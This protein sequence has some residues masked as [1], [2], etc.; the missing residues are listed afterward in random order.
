MKRLVLCGGLTLALV[1]A[2]GEVFAVSGTV[3]GMVVDGDGNPV[4]DASV[5][6]QAT[7]GSTLSFKGKT[8]KDGTFL[9]L[10]TG[11]SGPW[12][13]TVS[14]EGYR[15]W[16]MKEPVLIPL[17]GE[18]VVLPAVTLW[19]PD[20]PR[21]PA[22]LNTEE[23]KQLEAERKQFE[24]LSGEY[25]AVVTLLEASDA[26]Q[27][28]GDGALASQKL[29]EAEAGIRAL[30]AKNAAVARLPLTLG[31]VYEKRRQWQSAAEAYL[32]AAELKSDMADA[33]RGAAAMYLSAGQPKKAA[34]VCASGLAVNA[35]DSR[36]QFLLAWARFNEGNYA[37][38]TRQFDKAQQM[39]AADPEPNYYLGVI[40]VAQNRVADSLRLL[41]K[42][43]SMN[44]T[45]TR[46]LKSAQDMLL[47][48]R[49][50]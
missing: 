27:G 3:R 36:L 19:K 16:E 30:I 44:P 25:D 26:A 13:V 45:N 11:T 23:A 42:Y 17:G 39:D 15:T 2:S 10:T 7:R 4:A 49:K 14:K 1:M 12:K 22:V 32:K 9:Q 8:K 5:Q 34:D 43:V 37:E 33:Y 21:A 48:L 46:N 29:D 20:D 50:K 6:V 38:A 18:T 28:A 24:A 35:A 40:A 31:L 41:Q 47:A